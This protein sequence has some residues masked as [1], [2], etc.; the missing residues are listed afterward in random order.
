MP[1][2]SGF[3]TLARIQGPSA[4]LKTAFG[5]ALIAALA[6]CDGSPSHHQKPPIHR[7]ASVTSATAEVHGNQVAVAVEGYRSACDTLL[8]PLQQRTGSTIL[9]SIETERT[10]EVC[11]LV[12]IDWSQRIVL[13]GSFAP[14]EYRVR[15]NDVAAAFTVR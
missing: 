12:A 9:V 11:I 10:A 1:S 13:D 2:T 8:V 6:G 7:L 5:V 15:V 3:P 4:A 14:G